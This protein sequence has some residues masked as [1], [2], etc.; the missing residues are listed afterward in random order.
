M[1]ACFWS[2]QMEFHWYARAMLL[3]TVGAHDGISFS[4]IINANTSVHFVRV[5][6]IINFFT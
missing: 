5:F 4:Y 3:V 2:F 1:Q 6:N